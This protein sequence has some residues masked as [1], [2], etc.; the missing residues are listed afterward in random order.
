MEKSA[1]GMLY[2]EPIKMDMPK[3]DIHNIERSRHDRNVHFAA[4]CFDF[5][6]AILLTKLSFI[7][8]C[9]F[10]FFCIY[11]HSLSKFLY[12]LRT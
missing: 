3:R 2:G 7:S 9:I 8:K 5:P 11:A 1:L 6:N 4:S 10:V 12:L